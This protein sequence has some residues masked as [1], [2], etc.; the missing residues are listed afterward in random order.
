MGAFPGI[1]GVPPASGPKARQVPGGRGGPGQAEG[2]G[3][4]SRFS[5]DRGGARP[6]GGPSPPVCS[7]G[8]D[9]RDPGEHRWA[10]VVVD[11]ARRQVRRLAEPDTMVHVGLRCA[12]P[13]YGSARGRRRHQGLARPKR[14]CAS[15]WRPHVRRIKA[16]VSVHASAVVEKMEGAARPA[17]PR[18]AVRLH[19]PCPG[20][21]SPP[22]A[23]AHPPPS[24]RGAHR[25]RLGRE[26]ARGTVIRD[27]R[28]SATGPPVREARR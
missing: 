15:P 22:P 6:R 7:S 17:R 19:P 27:T 24:L 26:Q 4:R 25:R 11:L 18:R 12:N 1:A 28:P 14:F 2:A 21:I 3:C 5:R 13:T 16:S 8:R 23:P 20:S 10:Y 9:A